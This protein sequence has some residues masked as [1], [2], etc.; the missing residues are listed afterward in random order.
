MH[1]SLN[2]L[3][4]HLDLKNRSTEDIDNL[5]TFAGIEV[6]D[7]CQTGVP[8]ELIVVAKILDA[9]PHPNADRLKVCQVDAGEKSPRQI[10]CGAKNYKV[11]DKVPCALPGANLGEGF[12]IKESKLRGTPSSGMLCAAEEIGLSD[13]EDGLML[14]PAESTV[15]TPLQ[16]LF[17]SDTIFTIE[18]TPNRPDLLSH[19]GLARELAALL[20]TPLLKPTYPETSPLKLSSIPS[21]PLAEVLSSHF[22][23]SYYLIS[24]KGIKIAPSP[25]FIQKRLKSIGLTPINNVVDITNFVL[26]EVGQPLHA[27][28]ASKVSLPIIVE[29]VE[30]EKS[31]KALD[32][33]TYTLNTQDHLITDKN[34][35][36]LALAG[37]MGGLGSAVTQDTQDIL[38][39]IAYFDPS[40]IR[41]TSRRLALSSDSSYRFERGIDPQGLQAAATLASQLLIAYAHA[42]PVAMTPLPQSPAPLQQVQLNYAKLDSL[43]SGEIPHSQ[44]HSIL[45]GLGLSCLTRDTDSSTW[46][47]PSWR[48]DLSRHIDLVEEIVRVYGL[49]NLSASTQSTLPTPSLEDTRYTKTIALSQ[50]LAGLGL[51]ETHTIKLIAENSTDNTVAQVDN[52]LPLRPLIQGDLIKLALP[53]SEDHNLLRPSLIPG[54]LGVAARNLRQGA[55]S[56]RFFETGTIFRNMGGG[57]ARDFES[58]SLA[59]LIGGESTPLSWDQ[60]DTRVYDIFD[61][62]AILQQLLHKHPIKLIPSKREGFLLVNTLVYEGKPLGILAQLSPT[63]QRA[64]GASFPLYIAELDLHRVLEST[65]EVFAVAPLPP[66]PGSSRDTAMELPLNLE[67]SAIEKAIDA[68]KEPLLVSYQCFDLFIDPSG[69]KLPADKKS[70][71]YTFHYRSNQKTLKAKEVDAAH[72]ALLKSLENNLPLSFR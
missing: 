32:E 25:P 14:L 15:G 56:L 35:Q 26:H 46:A 19:R 49:D 24:F 8:S 64:L 33:H 40:S 60:K 58:S 43:T 20:H 34:K 42:T 66:F 69:E 61:L 68:H 65:R 53:L 54:L 39:E 1:I 30:S 28:D 13:E 57:K 17:A 11:G 52:A 4:T 27:F 41:Q 50:Q 47:I 31:F 29:K 44:A 23:S 12:I 37:V 38:L 72:A 59:I 51:H 55:K 70:I 67:N 21:E 5:L 2:W 6:E 7:I 45:E 63:R 71:A 16:E 18:V 36:A 62:K 9:Q 48:A 3:Q 10:V 22:C